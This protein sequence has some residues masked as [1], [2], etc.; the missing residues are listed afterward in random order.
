MARR[1]PLA[2][3][4]LGL[5]P[6]LGGFQPRLLGLA[7]RVV[8][9]DEARQNRL[10]A[11]GAEDAALGDLD[12]VLERLGQIGEHLRHRLGALEVV[13][14]RDAA[15]VV[16]HHVAPFRDAQQRIVRLVIIGGREVGLVGGDDRDL[17]R[18]GEPQELRLHLVLAPEAVALHLDVEPVAEGALQ[19][20]EARLR[21]RLLALAQGAVDGSV[22]AAGECDE[23]A[24]VRLERGGGGVHAL[25]VGRLEVGPAHELHQIGVARLVHGE[26][27]DRAVARFTRNRRALD[28]IG[29]VLLEIDVERNADDGL[30]AGL[31]ELVGE[32]Q[33]AEEIV[34]V[35]EPQRR[36]AISG[37][38]LGEL[39]RSAGRPRAGNRPSAP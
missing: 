8:A 25:G 37:G 19:L 12:R 15:A 23:P 31:G 22:G 11:L 33:R 35:G 16:L 4:L 27:R 9:G 24:R 14:A 30:D 34:G 7:D 5:A 1:Q 10:A 32:L 39:R 28:R 6:Q 13:L 2:Q 36:I 26:E 3:A 21:Q 20:E 29:L 18:V 17:V 38:E